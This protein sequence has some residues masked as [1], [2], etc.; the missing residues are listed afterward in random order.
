[1]QASTRL[2]ALCVLLMP[3]LACD[4]SQPII[5]LQ[6]TSR[7][8]TE[9][10]L[11]EM[12]RNGRHPH[13]TLWYNAEELDWIARDYAKR[14]DI[15][16]N[17]RGSKILIWVEADS[18]NLASIEYMHGLWEPTLIVRISKEGEAL[19]HVLAT[20]V[21]GSYIRGMRDELVPE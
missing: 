7:A 18:E 11:E 19:E 8:Y 20:A 5:L 6:P 21:D 3:L 9:A 14:N 10:Q 4:H 12:A 16:F 1:M 15:D 13:T 17:F 2:F